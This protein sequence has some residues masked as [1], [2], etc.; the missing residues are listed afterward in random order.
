MEG[1]LIQFPTLVASN[2]L[3]VV[4]KFAMFQAGEIERNE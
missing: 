1:G 3:I 2:G 4:H